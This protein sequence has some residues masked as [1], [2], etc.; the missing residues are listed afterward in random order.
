MTEDPPPSGASVVVIIAIAAVAGVTLVGAGGY[1]V[2][3]IGRPPL[4]LILVPVVLVAMIVSSTSDTAATK[5]AAAVSGVGI[6]GD[7]AQRTDLLRSEFSIDGTGVSVAIISDSFDCDD[8]AADDIAAGALPT[9]MVILSDASAPYCVYTTDRGRAIAEMVHAVAPGAS[10]M[11][12]K[13]ILG[14]SELAS[15]ITAVAAAGADIIV[16]DAW[17]SDEL[18]FQDDTLS[19]T[20]DQ[21]TS[22]GIIYLTAAGDTGEST[23]ESAFADGG[24]AGT[25]CAGKAGAYCV[26]HDFDPGAGVDQLLDVTFPGT[27]TV[28]SLQWDQPGSSAGGTANAT[29]VDLFLLDS[30]GTVI[31]SATVNNIASEEP[32]EVMSIT[33]VTDAKISVVYRDGD[34]PGRIKLIVNTNMTVNDHPSGSATITG[35]RNSASAITVGSVHYTDTDPFGGTPVTE[36]SSSQG[37]VEVMFATDGTP[38]DTPDARQKPDVVAPAGIETTLGT[39]KGTSAAA[40]HAAGLA[41][42]LLELGADMHATGA[43]GQ[44][45]IRFLLTTT[46][47]NIG[48]PGYDAESGYGLVDAL[49]AGDVLNLENPVA[50]PDSYSIDMNGSL[51]VSAP[52]ILAND[53]DANGH[54]IPAV[55]TSEPTNG[56]LSLVSDGS[57]I[58]T[59]T[60]GFIG[61]DSFT[62]TAT[63]GF[64]ASD[65]VTVEITVDPIESV[66]APLTLQGVEAG[67]S[68]G[69]ESPELA[70]TS[71][72]T[73]VTVTFAPD[74]A[75]TVQIT[76]LLPGIYTL[77]AS[78]PG[79][80][81]AELGG[82]VLGDVP[83]E[84][85]SVDAV[86]LPAGDS[87]S[88]GV[89][90]IADATAVANG[91][92]TVFT[93][94]QR[95]DA[96]DNVVD[97]NG[98]GVVN[99]ADLS[100]AI[101]NI[102]LSS[103]TAW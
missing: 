71:P 31:K 73:S 85:V 55:L 26:A 4:P 42:L 7:T 102:G 90:D 97:L 62:Y 87:N 32:V 5:K 75:S 11:S 6:E 58:Y 84:Q 51:D 46:A 96:S 77:T 21:V 1:V 98:D 52:G 54:D 45:Q 13:A 43:L 2:T 16:D 83:G 63:D 23:Y 3:R 103:P 57:F 81:S 56:N 76:G 99:A 69:I 60:P 15:A 14:K 38:L 18:V 95:R 74:T 9:D 8:G 65:P 101:S 89:I 48:A 12:H 25:L 50:Q 80:L 53:S 29:D 86:V 20:I 61:T 93:P 30:V 100:L 41:A 88:D 82:V 34:L 35:H 70:V 59:P 92:R 67:A 24:T 72:D 40:A 79:F 17:F 33:G 49:A 36:A 28:L 94:G 44:E 91:F 68:F 78:A 37:G 22:D 66:S 64:F 27:Q 19:Q 10:L 39:L 47:E